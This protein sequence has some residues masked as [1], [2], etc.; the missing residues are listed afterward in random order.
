[1]IQPRKKKQGELLLSC[2]LLGLLGGAGASFMAFDVG[3]RMNAL[4]D[5]GVV[6]A[7]VITGK[8]MRESREV[9]VNGGG[10]R[11]SQHTTDYTLSL[12][13]DIHAATRHRDFIAGKPVRSEGTPLAY[14][15]SI[16]VS[17][18][19][20]E[21]HA[22]GATIDV[23]FLPDIAGY[24]KDSF[25]LTQTVEEQSSFAFLIWWYLGAAAAFLF[26]LWGIAR[27]RSLN[28]SEA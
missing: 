12:N 13:F 3:S 1:M 20:Y 26:G 11:V 17:R 4:K 14:P 18:A 16:D 19:V 5:Q 24:D 6:S 28:R 22:E 15:G 27:Y 23:T 2:A 21:T 8:E 9:K 10:R 7:A 25:Q